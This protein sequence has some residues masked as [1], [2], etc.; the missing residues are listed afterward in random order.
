MHV[1]EVI[2]AAIQDNRVRSWLGR[3]PAD[4]TTFERNR[5]QVAFDRAFLRRGEINE[6]AL[7]VD[8]ADLIHH[9][10]ARGQLANQP[11]GAVVQVEVLKA[12]PLRRPDESA[13]L[14]SAISRL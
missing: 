2:P 13:V 12:I 11:A 9:P 5:V 7:L 8:P 6:I 10:L 14:A 3:D 4:L 1:D